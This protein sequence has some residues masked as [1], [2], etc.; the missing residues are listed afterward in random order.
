MQQA[1]GPSK[2]ARRA[3]ASLVNAIVNDGIIPLWGAIEMERTAICVAAQATPGVRAVNDHMV[4][5]PL[6]WD[7]H[8]GRAMGLI[9][10]KSAMQTSAVLL[11]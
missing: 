10:V 5:R 7:S 6:L 3:H 8:Q 4:V 2:G 11:Y 9:H 1:D